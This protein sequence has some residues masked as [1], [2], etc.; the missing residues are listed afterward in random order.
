MLAGL[1]CDCLRLEIGACSQSGF[2][3]E[4]EFKRPVHIVVRGINVGES[5]SI[6]GLN[7]RFMRDSDELKEVIVVSSKKGRSLETEITAEE[8]L[9]IKMPL[10]EE[11]PDELIARYLG[12]GESAFHYRA[13]LVRALELIQL[14]KAFVVED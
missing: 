4:N 8:P 7:L 14:R 12:I 10:G 3:C 6:Q 9:R 13:A 11:R 1:L 2:E 5:L